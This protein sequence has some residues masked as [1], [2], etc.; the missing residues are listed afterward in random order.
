M[1]IELGNT[2]ISTEIFSTKFA[3]HLEKCKGACC[4]EGD[5]GAPLESEEIANIEKHLDVI[6]PFLTKE[7]IEVIQTEGF[8]EGIEIDDPSTNC[9]E[10]GECVFAYREDGI[11]GCAIEKA[12]NEGLIPFS[13]PI[14]CHLYP[15]RV[16]KAG[17]K[18]T[19]NYHEWSICT[20]ACS[21]GK[22]LHLP[23]YRFLK[24]PLIR[25]YGSEWYNEL[26]L[27]YN[28]YINQFPDKK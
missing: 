9:L 13:K 26:E 7:S 25:Q 12:E 27:V 28:E 17:D 2:L 11:L 19:L 3:C 8:H 18:D 5:R 15:I 24:K 23:L 10:T 4:V 21:L 22:E 20:P 6:K 1:I 16:G 14:S